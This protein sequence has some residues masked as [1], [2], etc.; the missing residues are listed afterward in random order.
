MTA[1]FDTLDLTATT[2]A[3]AVIYVRVSSAAQVAKGQGAES[4]AAR[5]ADFA[6]MRGYKVIK[7]FEDKAVSGSLIDRPGMQQLLAY[8]RKHRKDNIRVLID[9]ISRL[10]RGLEAHLALRAAISQAGGMLESPSIEFGED[11]DSQLIE[12]LLASV[13]Q[14]A[15]VKNAEQ[16][17]NRMEARIRQGYWPFAPCI[18]YTMEKVDGHGKLLVRDEPIASIIQEALEGYASG[19]F[20][21]Q[22]EVARFLQAQKDFPKTRVGTVTVEAANRLL[23]RVLYAG[24]VERSEWG[25]SLRQ[26]KH[27]GL[28]DFTTFE[29]IQERLK[30]R[31][32][33][34]QRADLNA[35]FP[36]RGAVACAECG[37]PLTASWSKSK[38][39]DEHP[40][41]MCYKKGCGSYR[42]S[43]RRADIETRFEEVLETL[44]PIETLYGMVKAM[45]TDAWDQQHEAVRKLKASLKQELKSL[46][47][48]I[49]TLLSRIVDATSE[50]VIGAYETKID[51]LE[52]EKLILNEKIAQRAK[53][54]RSFAQVFELTLE[55]LKNPGNLWKSDRLEDKQ[56]VLRLVFSQP[57]SYDRKVGFRTPKTSSIFKVLQDFTEKNKVMAETK[58]FEPSIPLPVYSLSRGALSTTQPRLRRRG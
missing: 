29:K 33:A 47:S 3:K 4:Q 49:E 40:Y 44:T 43:I 34:P 11:S 48:Q 1:T 22:A 9:D 55:F 23:N 19:R 5:C 53:P 31:A 32:Y 28:I 10:A 16:T 30:G 6:R 37:N 18:G 52:R 17:R 57:L 38:T 26:G 2:T 50:R 36:L 54:R 45:F 7:T 20:V 51:T 21:S 25:V 35:D 42:K 15:R 8:V 27:Q 14:H 56:T 13:S 41:Y 24:M 58:G 12:H 46:D 39:G